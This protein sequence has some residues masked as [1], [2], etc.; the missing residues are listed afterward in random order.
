LWEK[1]NEYWFLFFFANHSQHIKLAYFLL[2]ITIVLATAT[3]SFKFFF[4]ANLIE[5]GILRIQ[6]YPILI[7]PSFNQSDS[8]E[9]LSEKH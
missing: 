2:V 1:S 7:G 4:K 6:D 9:L 5:V 8:F 3:C